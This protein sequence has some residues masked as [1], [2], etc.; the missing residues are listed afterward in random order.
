MHRTPLIHP[1]PRLH[2][3][4]MSYATLEQPLAR[5]QTT[6]SWTTEYS[7]EP[8]PYDLCD[9]AALMAAAYADKNSS[10]RRQPDAAPPPGNLSRTP[11]GPWMASPRRSALDLSI[12][13]LREAILSLDSKMATLLNERDLLE[14]RLEHAVR[15][16]SPVQR[17]PNDLLASIFS[18]AVLEEE[19]EDS[20]TLSNLMLVCRWWREVAINS[21]MLWTRIVMG[22]HHSVDRAILKLDRSRTAP[23][24]VCLDFSPRMEHGT[25]STE[26]IVTAMELVR[27]AIWRW[28]TF[29]LVVPSRPQAHVAL[30]RCKEQAP[31]L[32]ILSV[33]VSHSMQED[34]YSKAPLPLFERTTPRLRASSFT[35]FNFGW[36]LALLSNLRVLKLGGYWNGFSPSVDT[37]LKTLRSCPQLEELVLRNMSDVDPD[38]CTTSI[39]EPSEHDDYVLARASD[40]RPI[41][42]P[43][44]RKA[45][46]YYS[47]NLRTRTVLTLL[48]FPALER[49]ELCYLDNVS[50]MLEALRRQSLT[51]LPLRHLRIESCFFNELRFARLLPRLPALTSLELVDVEDVTSNLMRV[52]A[53]VALAIG[54]NDDDPP[55][56]LPPEPRD[57]PCLTDLGVP[58]ADHAVCRRMLVARVGNP[59]L[60]RRVPLAPP[61]SRVPPPAPAPSASSPRHTSVGRTAGCRYVHRVGPAPHAPPPAGDVVR[62]ESVV[63]IVL[64]LCVRRVGAHPVPPA[65]G[66]RAVVRVADRRPAG[67]AR[68]HRPHALPTD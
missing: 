55:L 56:V 5:A 20:I 34:H 43:R 2:P 50:P 49:I 19:D 62:R 51:V 13:H 1:T 35:S 63:G 67:P 28:K 68:E 53:A 11:A 17:L 26:S 60:D 41:S 12:P 15:M 9:T 48:S 10:L 6:M 25:V 65:V 29:H 66:A 14:L 47:G 4:A 61:F 39:S 38:N 18:I 3:S 40:T 23:I 31:Q 52:S 22:T 7:T 32:E 33:R 36:D 59:P 37:L 16:N 54:D 8:P 45:S 58:E 64:G 21:P 42:L 24:H 30:S 44:L 27:P 46:F 57:A